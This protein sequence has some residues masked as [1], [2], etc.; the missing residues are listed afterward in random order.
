MQ[1]ATTTTKGTRE[2]GAL[3]N[4]SRRTARHEDEPP[5][6]VR[7]VRF[8]PDQWL[9]ITA[10]CDEL[11]VQVGKFL[12]NAALAA[13]GAPTEATNL[14]KLADTL[15]GLPGARARKPASALRPLAKTSP[16]R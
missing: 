16:R 6:I 7:S 3:A 12:R 1:S 14:R 8:L 15:D 4:P 5:S 10:K 2:G 11:G 13:A 9:V